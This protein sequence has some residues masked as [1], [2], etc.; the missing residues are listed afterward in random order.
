LDWAQIVRDFGLYTKQRRTRTVNSTGVVRRLL[1]HAGMK[2]ASTR[3][4]LACLLKA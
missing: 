2:K 4:A 3:L 1:L